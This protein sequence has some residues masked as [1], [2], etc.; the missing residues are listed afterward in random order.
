MCLVAGNSL[1]AI[2]SLLTAKHPQ[3]V[4]EEAPEPYAY[5]TKTKRKERFLAGIV[6]PAS[7]NYVHGLVDV[8]GAV[9][10]EAPPP[11][12]GVAA[13]VAGYKAGAPRA[14]R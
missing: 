1:Q 10:L 7:P 12:L 2:G 4:C 14:E 8:P 6:S 9:P 11:L 5:G 3:V 13:S